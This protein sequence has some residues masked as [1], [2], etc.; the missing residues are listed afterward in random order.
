V[1]I[2][3]LPHVFIVYLVLVAGIALIRFVN[4][5]D[6]NKGKAFPVQAMKAY[7]GSRDIGC[8]IHILGT[9]G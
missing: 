8:L 2:C 4:G 9:L 6:T 5:K 1:C 7:V 3:F